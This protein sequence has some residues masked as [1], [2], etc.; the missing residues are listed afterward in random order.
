MARRSRR[1]E[2]W[3]SR[4]QTQ[5][6]PGRRHRCREWSLTSPTPRWRGRKT[7]APNASRRTPRWRVRHASRVHASRK[8]PLRPRPPTTDD[9]QSPRAGRD[10]SLGCAETTERSRSS[11]CA[12]ATCVARFLRPSTTTIETASTH[13]STAFALRGAPATSTGGY[14]QG[15][16]ASAVPTSSS[17]SMR[18]H[19]VVPVTEGV[20]AIDSEC[21]RAWD[22]PIASGHADYAGTLL[23][24]HRGCQRVDPF[25]GRLRIRIERRRRQCN[26]ISGKHCAEVMH[27]ARAGREHPAL[28][29]EA[30]LNLGPIGHGRALPPDAAYRH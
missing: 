19:D 10:A 16:Q 4:R 18:G 5:V 27:L 11:G 25:P 21:L 6:R 1:R 7:W 9:A 24:M 29:K 22:A 8:A 14:P 28:V 13:G 3:R 12:H 20:A 2:G 26:G 30:G 17:G 15:V 23:G